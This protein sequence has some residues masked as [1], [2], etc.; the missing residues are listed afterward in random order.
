[1]I[2]ILEFFNDNRISL[3]FNYYGI[4]DVATGWEIKSIID[5]YDFF[6]DLINNSG[7]EFDSIEMYYFYLLLLKLSKYDEVI[8][9]LK[10][11]EDKEKL[12]RLVESSIE[13]KEKISKGCIIKL[14]NKKHEEIFTSENYVYD[15]DT[16]SLELIKQ[17]ITGISEQ[18]FKFLIRNKKYLII[19]NYSDFETWFENHPDCFE[20]LFPSGKLE[21]CETY[22][23]DSILDIWKHLYNKSHT[24]HKEHIDKL[25]YEL[26]EDIVNVAEGSTIDTVM[27]D[28]FKIRAFDSFLKEIKS[29]LANDFKKYREATEELN[30]KYV[31]ERGQS[32]QYEIPIKEIMER[33]RSYTNCTTKLFSLTHNSVQEGEKYKYY[34]ALETIDSQN[35]PILDLVSTNVPINDF[36]TL[37]FQQSLS[38]HTHC[39]S[40]QFF[41]F[42][43]NE[44]Y[45]NEF[46]ELYFSAIQF[47][48]K[49]LDDESIINDGTYFFDLLNVLSSNLKSDKDLVKTLCYAPAMFAC[50]FIEKL[51]RVF[52]KYLVKDSLYVPAKK[53]TLGQLLSENNKE[54]NEVFGKKHIKILSFYLLTSEPNDVGFNYRNRLAHW[55]EISDG[56]VNVSMISLLLYLF[57]DVLNSILWY[58]LEN[59]EKEIE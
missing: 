49:C 53:A 7:E 47:V 5:N 2:N 58:F 35:D 14:I 28:S 10:N 37:S 42:L 20:M 24:N 8:P 12:N 15:V 54:I 50:A 41:W 32:F 13:R 45:Q 21:D 52:Y 4:N 51:L 30:R 33:W 39:R 26:Y 38:I 29:P 22:H 31:H 34:S 18:V 1:M 56:E 48:S 11:E 6:E 43:S 36:F 27:I 44:D 19:S 59:G 57:V 46:F 9:Y 25:I 55:S 23:L 16:V 40:S 3:S 17:Y